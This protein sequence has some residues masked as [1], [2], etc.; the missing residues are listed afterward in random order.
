MTFH[1]GSSVR[2]KR[3]GAPPELGRPTHLTVD[4]LT[5]A[6]LPHAMTTRHVEG[7]GRSGDADALL[8]SAAA[9]ILASVNLDVR[10]VAFARQAHGAT[11][12]E[13]TAPGSVGEADVILSAAPGQPL[14]IFT[15]DCLPVVLYEPGRGRLA[16]VHA[17]WR[18]TVAGVSARAVAGMAQ[19]GADPARVVAAI[20]P[21]IGPCCYE[22]E[23]MVVGPLLRAY[24]WA[25][26]W[27]RRVGPVDARPGEPTDRW[28]LDLWG[29]NETQLALA[30]VTELNVYN[31]RFCTACHTDLLYSYRR[32]ARG[33]LVTV[34]ALPG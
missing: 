18:G 10:R 14:A 25:E 5:A 32:G 22:V 29:V 21:S 13:A 12:A 2:V 11:I 6:L 34:A 19:G 26:R 1:G 24:P 30:G 4:A 8:H 33:R 20:G 7:S 15:A 17:G 3:E 28:M 31:T 23:A 27:L 16:L 9:S